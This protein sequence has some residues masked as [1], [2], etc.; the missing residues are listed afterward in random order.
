MTAGLALL[1]LDTATVATWLYDVAA[2]P[3]TFACSLVSAV[4]GGLQV[5]YKTFTERY[6]EF[7]SDSYLALL[8]STQ[9]Q[10]EPEI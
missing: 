1:S 10:S 3:L 5:G 2:V 6:K 8:E 7:K 4:V 9:D